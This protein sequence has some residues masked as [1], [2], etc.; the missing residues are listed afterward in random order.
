MFWNKFPYTDFHELNLDMI[1]EEIQKLHEDW[2]EFKV[3]N[4]ITFMGE[5]KITKQYPAW[6]IVNTDNGTQGYIS[7][8]PVP[9]GIQITNTDYWQSVVDYT[10]TI[11]DLQN[12]LIIAEGNITTLQSQVAGILANDSILISDSYGVV[13]VVGSNNWVDQLK[14]KLNSIYPNATVRTSRHGSRGFVPNNLVDEGFLDSLK[15]F[16]SLTAAEKAKVKRIVVCGGCNDANQTQADIESSI[17]DFITYA[18]TNYPN[19]EVYIG[20]IGYESNPVNIYKKSLM[21]YKNAPAH[22]GIYLTGVDN[23]LRLTMLQGDGVH[24]TSDGNNEISKA[25]INSLLTGSYSVKRAKSDLVW[26]PSGIC[27]AVSGLGVI[28]EQQSD[29]YDIISVKSDA[30]DSRIRLSVTKDTWTTKSPQEVGT[31]SG[32]LCYTHGT[33]HGNCTGITHGYFR[34]GQYN[35]PIAGTNMAFLT[36]LGAGNKIYISPLGNATGA[37][38]WGDQINDVVYVMLDDFCLR[39]GDSFCIVPSNS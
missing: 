31:L 6:A 15:E 17:D 38:Y 4:A 20:M 10:A 27:T 18:K 33:A 25:V 22:G 24:P 35:A 21:A 7:I 37:D 5:W 28:C 1:L 39:S 8:K 32:H 14:T 30:Q 9:P 13:S 2:D 16:D 3:L 12:R 19:A 26:T 23:A 34:G 36:W 29:D 11:A